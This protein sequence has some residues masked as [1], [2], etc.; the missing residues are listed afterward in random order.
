MG[1]P[2]SL[3]HREPSALHRCWLRKEQE[4]ENFAL[5]WRVALNLLKRKSTGTRGLKAKRLVAGW[6][7]DCLLKVVAEVASL[8]PK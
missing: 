6:N 5:L 2:L 8:Q 4:A 3:E 1:N 7:N